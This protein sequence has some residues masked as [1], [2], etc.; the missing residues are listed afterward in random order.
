M[1]VPEVEAHLPEQPMVGLAVTVVVMV[2]VV[3]PEVL[4]QVLELLVVVVMVLMVFLFSLTP[5]QVGH[6]N[7]SPMLIPNIQLQ[8]PPTSKPRLLPSPL[9]LA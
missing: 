2:V 5:R 1:V 3:V 4:P 6:Q 7:G 8:Y 9:Q